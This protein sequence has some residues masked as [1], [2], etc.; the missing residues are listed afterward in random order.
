MFLDIFLRDYSLYERLPHLFQLLGVAA[1]IFLVFWLLR[2]FLAKR[3]LGFLLKLA[4]QTETNLDDHLI[5]AFEKPLQ[6]FFVFL[7][8]YLALYYLP[9]TPGQ[10]LMALKFFRSA[11]ILCVTMG[12]YSFLGSHPLWEGE[13]QGLFNLHLD[14]IL[15]AF[16]VKICKAILVGLALCII[17][18]EW[19][20]NV[21]GF[22][23]GLGLGGL[24]F[25]LA[26]QD[27]LANIFGGIVI[28]TDKPF[29]IG[30]WIQTPTVEGTVED[31]NFRSTRIRTFAQAVVT[32]PN[33]TLAN[34]AI[35][36]WSRMGKRRI[37]F[38]LKIP[39]KTPKEELA[40]CLEQIRNMLKGHPDIDKET[41]LVNLD[42]FG[43][44][45]WNIYFYFFTKATSFAEYLKAK[46]DVNFKIMEILEKCRIPVAFPGTTVYMESSGEQKGQK[47]S[48]LGEET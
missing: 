30:D 25:A 45:S 17:A 44:S 43:E 47:R 6:L 23:A 4:R 36:N 5:S 16:L 26:A 35:T 13:L 32:V 24:A 41:V 9:L 1:A 12:L 22:I 20:Y 38:N 37:T 42:S 10:D 33:K 27:T 3:I 15:V 7:G 8:L 11:I 31:I 48:F 39:Y 34:E 29:T 19:E 28:I 2:R 14:K 18:G 40:N 21:S 46:E